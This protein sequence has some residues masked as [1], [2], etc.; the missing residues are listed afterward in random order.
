M[1]LVRLI[2]LALL[3]SPLFYLLAAL[4][5]ALLPA[6]PRWQAPDNGIIIYVRSNGVHTSLVLPVIAHDVD[7]GAY[8]VAIGPERPLASHDHV[9]FAWGQREFYL[10]TPQWADLRAGVAFRA[11]MGMG[12]SL[13]HVE[14]LRAPRPGPHM[15]VLRL[16]PAQYRR[17]ALFIDASVARRDNGAILPVRRGYGEADMF[18]AARGT[19]DLLRTSNVWTGAALRHAG[20]RMGVWTPFAQSIMWRL[21]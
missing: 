18:F 2:V 10:T 3:L 14:H 7:W 8:L 20:V 17:L 1:R 15:R 4:G 21:D 6:N 16:T 11:L 13:M 5:G 12:D 19:Y 9:S